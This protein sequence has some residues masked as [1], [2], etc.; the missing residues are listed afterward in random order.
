MSEVAASAPVGVDEPA[1][2]KGRGKRKF[3][4]PS[5]FTILFAVTIIAALCTYF[6]PAGQYSKLLYDSDTGMLQMTAP[7][8]E[9]VELDATQETL[10]E[11]GVKIDIDQFTSGAI[12]KAVSIPGTY[13]SLPQ[14][15]FPFTDIPYAMVY[16]VI[17][18]IDVM[19][20]ILCL[21]GL[22]GAVKATGAFESGLTALTRKTKGREFL[23]VFGVSCFMIFGGTMCG[24][25]EEAVAFYPILAPV[26]IA[27][28][29]DS[30]VTVG[31]IFMASSVGTTFSTVN[32]FSAVIASNA[33]GTV[34]TEGL[35]VRL[36]GLIVASVVYLLYLHWYSKKVKANPEFSYAYEDSAKF[37][38]MWKLEEDAGEKH[39]FTARK[40][41]VLCIFVAAFIIMI[42]GVMSL[43]WWFPQM[44]A[45][46]VT[47]A[48][49]VML[50]GG[51]GKQGIGESKMVEAFSAGASSLVP[52][53]LII[54]LARGVN[55]VLNSG[56]ISDTMLYSASNVVAGMSGPV[57]IIALL[58]IFFVLGFVVPSS[59]GLAVLSMPIFAPLADTVGI[60]RWI[61]VAAYQFGQY[62]ML[63]IA[64]T[65][66]IMATLQMLDMKMSHWFRFVWP[67]MVFTL[68]FGAVLLSICTI[69]FAV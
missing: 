49:A 23:L 45:E 55:Y 65:G 66:L 63:Y 28:G 34:F 6:V 3:S 37:N 5:A 15:P 50:I 69:V 19:V 25:E 41:I 17:D 26:F 7:S 14:N 51:C 39:V 36:L 10:D 42:V 61:I 54:G 2:K 60:P 31:A 22:I 47:L 58:L 11:L 67:M 44:A 57:F 53:A 32:P 64:P 18:G 27:L 68:V 21:G 29:Y 46:F 13:E 38:A 40:K 1:G 59:S 20:F 35:W 52:V 48:I 16:G 24:L 43:G 56:L 9:V 33:A 12:T 4:F 30:I 8:G 62:A